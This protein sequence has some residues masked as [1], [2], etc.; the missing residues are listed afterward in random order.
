MSERGRRLTLRDEALLWLGVA[1]APLAWTFHLTIAYGYDEAVCSTATGSG[2][3]LELVLALT[4]LCGALAL[5]GGAAAFLTWRGARRGEL[6]DPRGRVTFMSFA[7]MLSAVV[8]GYAIL[9]QGVLV[10]VLDA[11]TV[12]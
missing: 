4:G 7:G 11:C 2:A 8:F 1:G 12:G 3:L 9:L 10:L 5:A 6:L